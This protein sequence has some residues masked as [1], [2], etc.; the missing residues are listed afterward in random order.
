MLF[1][2]YGDKHEINPWIIQFYFLEFTYVSVR[3]VVRQEVISETPPRGDPCFYM[4]PG[5]HPILFLNIS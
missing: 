5:V 2:S 3:N 4:P 1:Y